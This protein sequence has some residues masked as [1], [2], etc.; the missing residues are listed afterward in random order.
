M[1]LGFQWVPGRGCIRPLPDPVPPLRRLHRRQ[2]PHSG[3]TVTVQA[4]VRWWTDPWFRVLRMSQ[5]IKAK[6]VEIVTEK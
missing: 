2:G 1:A 5:K 6:L 4:A 3:A